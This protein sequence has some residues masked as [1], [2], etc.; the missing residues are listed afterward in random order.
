MKN[1]I[2]ISLQRVLILSF[3]FSIIFLSSCNV[4]YRPV[5][6]NTPMLSQQGE[7]QFSAYLDHDMNF[8]FQ[9]ALAVTDNIG[10]IVNGG[11][12]NSL[13]LDWTETEFIFSRPH[14]LYLKPLLY[15]GELGLG[16][17]GTFLED[18]SFEVYGGAGL[19][20]IPQYYDTFA[21]IY[22]DDYDPGVD[23]QSGVIYKY[24]VQSA[25]GNTIYFGKMRVERNLALRLSSVSIFGEY[26]YLA[27]PAL[28]F[29]F[30]SKRVRFVTSVGLS[31]PIYEQNPNSWK[32]V[33]VFY[34]IGAQ[35]A[36]GKLYDE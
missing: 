27:E 14:S 13:A 35:I 36:I 22:S 19:G 33:P 6:I 32:H 4:L 15:H 31:Y 12:Y 3:F 17:F 29:K 16:Y 5:P 20:N 8:D 30:G 26:K 9:T 7:T 23:L 34:G 28:S 25:V 21:A 11:L 18:K 10:V 2:R 1:N 24:F